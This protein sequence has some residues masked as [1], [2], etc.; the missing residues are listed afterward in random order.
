[1]C[2]FFSD[3]NFFYSIFLFRNP[4]DDANVDSDIFGIDDE[5]SSCQTSNNKERPHRC[6]IG[7]FLKNAN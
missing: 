2:A 3:F 7:H 6:I 5:T 4:G 1:M